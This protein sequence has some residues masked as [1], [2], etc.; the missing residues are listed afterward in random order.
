MATDGSV[1][2]SLVLDRSSFDNDLK[3]L[4]GIDIPA[5][6]VPLKIDQRDFARQIK[7]LEG[8]IEPISVPVSADLSDFKKAVANLRLDPIK[9]D[10]SPN[11]DDFQEKLRRLGK[12]SPVNVDIQFNT[13]SVKQQFREIG[14]LAQAGFS[15][16][17]GS[18][19]GRDAAATLVKNVRQELDIHSPSGVF[20][21]I[22]K[23][24]IEG[25]MQGLDSIDESRL[26]GVVGK[27]EDYFKKIDI[28]VDLRVNADVSGSARV[29]AAV[30][31]PSITRVETKLDIGKFD[32]DLSDAIE[33]GM[34]KSTHKGALDSLLAPLK[35]IGS[36]ALSVVSAPIKAL[37]AGL[38]HTYEGLFLGAGLPLGEKLG[39]GISRGVEGQVSSLIGSFEVLGEKLITSGVPK[40][41][42]QLGNTLGGRI[43]SALIQNSPLAD[44]KSQLSSELGQII[45]ENDR[46]IASSATK[47][48]I[49]T[50]SNDRKKLAQTELAENLQGVISNEPE[51]LKQVQNIKTNLLPPLTSSIA[52]Q[53]KGLAELQQK[54]AAANPKLVGSQIKEIDTKISD[55]KLDKEFKSLSGEGTEQNDKAIAE[56]EA[57]KLSI[58]E[59]TK[60]A[61]G[62]D[63][64][65]A[66]ASKALAAAVQRQ[67]E[68]QQEILN[69]INAPTVAAEQLKK[70]GVTDP[71][72][73]SLEKQY[74]DIGKKG[75]ST[76]EPLDS[77]IIK[78]L[79]NIK[80]ARQ[81]VEEYK[82]KKADLEK[83][84][85]EQ[86]TSGGN[87]HIALAASD[88]ISHTDKMI[89]RADRFIASSR[90]KIATG[91]EQ[92]YDRGNEIIGE[93]E[94]LKPSIAL[95]QESF[96]KRTLGQPVPQHP[97]ASTSIY[98][99]VFDEV[100][101]LSGVQVPPGAMPKIIPDANL[102]VSHGTYDYTKNTVR[103]KPDIYQRLQKGE[104]QESDIGT[105]THELRHAVQ[106]DFGKSKSSSYSDLLSPNAEEIKKFG[107]NIEGSTSVQRKEYQPLYRKLEA[108]A[109][110]FQHRNTPEITSKL[111]REQSLEQ[112]QSNFGVGGV[113]IGPFVEGIQ[114]ESFKKIAELTKS[115][116]EKGVDIRQEMKQAIASSDSL[117]QS[118]QPL[119]EKSASIES[120][121]N[122]EIT[123]LS[124]EIKSTFESIISQM[125]QLPEQLKS[126]GSAK[127]EQ[128][129]PVQPEAIAPPPIQ[130]IENPGMGLQ[131]RAKQIGE[132]FKQKSSEFKNQIGAA[133]ELGDFK[134][135]NE[136]IDMFVKLAAEGKKE[137]DEIRANLIAIGQIEKNNNT[138][139]A[140][141][142]KAAIT[143]SVQK[144]QSE[145]AK[146]PLA[147]EQV[148]AF[149]FVDQVE[150]KY[151]RLKTSGVKIGQNLPNAIASGIGGGESEAIAA[152]KEM[153]ESLPNIVEQVL[154]IKSPSKVFQAIGRFITEGLSMG[155]KQ[156]T[157]EVVGAME[158]LDE[159]TQAIRKKLNESMGIKPFSGT[160]EELDKQTE[161]IKQKL[162]ES[163][164]FTPKTS[165]KLPTPPWELPKD[166][167]FEQ[168][169]D[170][171]GDNKPRAR[172]N[173]IPVPPWELPGSKPLEAETPFSSPGMDK[174]DVALEELRNQAI[175]HSKESLKRLK[176]EVEKQEEVANKVL[177]DLIKK[178]E[179]NAKKIDTY[180]PQFEQQAT[181][182]AEEVES[183]NAYN[184][185]RSNRKTT[186]KVNDVR[187]KY[188]LETAPV[189][190]EKYIP[191]VKEAAP[192]PGKSIFGELK[193]YRTDAIR[194]QA[195]SL[196]QQAKALLVDVE[197]QIVA[198]QAAEKE[199]KVIEAQIRQNE[200]EINKLLAEVGKISA[201]KSKANLQDVNNRITE[202]GGRIDE[203]KQRLADINPSI[204]K[205]KELQ[206]V[207]QK[208]RSASSGSEA[209]ANKS[210]ISEK[211]IQQMQ[212]YNQVLRENISVLGQTPSK[213]PMIEQLGGLSKAANLLKTAIGG[214]FAFQGVF[215]LQ[216][217]LK[218]VSI[219]AFKAYTELDRMKTALDFASG[220]SGAG[221][222]NLAFVK[223]TVDDLGIPLQASTA[224]FTK[225][226]AATRNTALEGKPAK[227]IFTGI[228]DASTV[229]SLSSEDTQASIS[230]LAEMESKGKVGAEEL[231]LELGDRIPGAMAI[232]ARATGKTQEEFTRM[233]DAG[234]ILSD[235]FLPKFGKQ[236][237]AEFGESAKT[238]SG[239]AASAVF[240]V[241][242]AFLELQQTIGGAIAPAVVSG[243]NLLAT[244]LKGIGSIAKEVAIAVATL[245]TVMLGRMVMALRTI[246]MEFILTKAAGG[247]L[248][249]G[250]NA[251]AS[252]LNRSPA[253]MWTA[254]IFALLEVINLLNQAVNTELVTSFHK[255]AEAAREAADE[256]RKAFEKPGKGEN[257]DNEPESSSG[258]GRFIDK[259]AIGGLNKIPGVNLQTYGQ[260]ERDSINADTSSIAVSTEDFLGSA[261][262]RLRQL[263][264]RTGDTGKIP[265]IDAQLKDAEESRQITQAEIQRNYTDK[266]LAT[267]ASEQRKLEGQDLAIRDLN[268]RRA[269]ASKPFTLDLAKTEQQITSIKSQIESLKSPEAIKAI[270]GSEAALAQTQVLKASLEKLKQFKAD[271]ES[272]LSS[273]RIDPLLAFTNA[274]RQLNLAFAERQEKINI[275]AANDKNSIIGNQLATFGTNRYG[276]REANVRL[277]DLD[278]QK[279]KAEFQNQQS[280]SAGLSKEISRPEF[281]STLRRLGVDQGS[282]AARINDVLQN[283]KDEN[284][285]AVLE[286]LKA[287]RE[288]QNNVAQSQGAYTESRL[289]TKSSV[290]DYALFRSDE[291]ASI[292]AAALQNQQNLAETFVKRGQAARLISEEQAAKQLAQIQ[293][294]TTA[295]QRVNLQA[296]LADIQDRYGKGQ[297]SAEEFYKRDRDL[298]N[299]STALEKQQ[300]EARLSLVQAFYSERVKLD[301]L[302]NKKLESGSAIAQSRS[303]Q[304]AKEKLLVG[305]LNQPAQDTFAIA[306][307]AIAQ[308]AAQDSI[309]LARKKIADN[310]NLYQSG[311]IDFQTYQGQ[312]YS[313]EQDMAQKSAALTDL[314]IQAEEKWRDVAEHAIQRVMAAED[315]R[316]KLLESMLSS[317]KAALEDYS[318][319]LDRTAKLESSR[320]NLAKAQSDAAISPLE[321]DKSGADRSMELAKKLQ[322][323]GV[324]PRV[325]SE[326]NKQLSDNGYGKSELEILAQRAKIEDEIFAKKMAGLKQE[327]AAQQ[328]SLQ[329]DLQKQKIAAENSV[330]DAI[331]AQLAAKKSELEAQG[332]LR[333][334]QIK[335]DDIAAQAASIGIQIAQKQGDLADRRLANSLKSLGIEDEL[336]KNATQSQEITQ[337][338]AL[339]QQ[340]A[341]NDSRKQAESLERV[342]ILAGK[343]SKTGSSSGG[344]ANNGHYD[345]AGRLPGETALQAYQREAFG[346]LKGETILDAQKRQMLGI[347]K[348]GVSTDDTHSGRPEAPIYGGDINK[349]LAPIPITPAIDYSGYH[350]DPAL[351][352]GGA[353]N[354]VSK[355]PVPPKQDSIADQIAEKLNSRINPQELGNQFVEALKGSNKGVENKLDI[356]IEKMSAIASAPRHLTV[357]TPNPVDDAAKIMNDTSRIL[358]RNSGI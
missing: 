269:E 50:V 353:N 57:K 79:E 213:P 67:G 242:N 236:L 352:G 349:P 163:M 356:L 171:W 11:V 3:K 52:T 120:L 264:S 276:G 224:G 226:A 299:Q 136:Q 240:G 21:D 194:K 334:A 100:T 123:K 348:K 185:A 91:A 13:D 86:I 317:Q 270:G 40:I 142:S 239:N 292:R 254:G 198:G 314:K 96:A 72:L 140:S 44:L 107:Q 146:D 154:Q 257:Q 319:E 70:A 7:G 27:I 296:Q 305:G 341:A 308:K 191:E 18:D 340:V 252:M 110:T 235:D 9:V 311:L 145:F 25:L 131:E 210:S 190:L 69:L 42:D 285:K 182:E 1:S 330:F 258:V 214:F 212:E 166:S 90:E 241:Q 280:L 148:K 263:K 328:E 204:V 343:A 150:D 46:L 298:S 217:A 29:G 151:Q 73:E 5:M 169:A 103:V 281:Q 273:L 26:R 115:F 184:E 80:A 245:A 220:G 260:L 302:A 137:L 206:P 95:A 207:A 2:I 15:E 230:A 237:Q 225:L 192:V 219:D 153:A 124:N 84:V 315:N 61:Q 89:S 188:G 278:E 141:K 201:G 36:G 170:P 267:P 313:L 178:A 159:E 261:R 135:V 309:A 17:I 104:I 312:Q 318:S 168:I 147:T 10:L 47:R 243:M 304:A 76:I 290:Q 92:K 301:E 130:Q 55:L 205:G 294:K 228:S 277:A 320:A 111:Q 216:D 83:L 333:V 81:K 181:Q 105:L 24:A 53:Q 255:S 180:L 45:G 77:N 138:N 106:A 35:S 358:M 232:A 336:E 233:L 351:N 234:E 116:N 342:E 282:S 289:K 34:K 345:Y 172:A 271:A 82:N 222:Q 339:D 60:S 149:P 58:Q 97:V 132:E 229:L 279:A 87:P 162:N 344:L 326:I 98:Q 266:G 286:K 39:E 183:R 165:T 128:K 78:E 303:T 251:V 346:T 335:K 295:Q 156:G 288:Q 272:A 195:Q 74:K 66:K 274:L 112:F 126:L 71:V 325:A 297:I 65:I 247:T 256:S 215:I 118:L 324:D 117:I 338:T 211:E 20:R 238:A 119:L 158:L 199:A 134:T 300:A 12:I 176:V 221:S 43:V 23:N 56:L 287:S 102:G 30:Q 32:A 350:Y 38:S 306:Q 355:I 33:K 196:S 114:I 99:K 187:N 357:S 202:V 244:T 262:T 129:I 51:R 4:Q 63:L 246:A 197:G 31:A 49:R 200:A 249:G 122:D 14:N 161:E 209:I 337:Q 218:Q 347:W 6:P 310:K 193:G 164:G 203:D 88:E 75:N 37:G 139:E 332:A 293:L 22:G 64:E 248:M 121:A 323:P 189:E 160:L 329:L 231:R 54:K 327:Q 284:D 59:T 177:N 28:K 174:T 322:D 8:F 109:Y 331:S 143:R 94:K 268:D 167:K 354:I 173:K 227:E 127:L 125:R 283:T 85:Q 253:V 307:V 113:K 16:G 48:Q 259:Y 179:A 316:A 144:V 19:I 108:D 275:G 250:L 68:L 208:L 186:R 41:G 155:I 321:L 291:S 62:I 265:G 175:A 133:Q 157:P 101:K 93:R 152:A 223:K